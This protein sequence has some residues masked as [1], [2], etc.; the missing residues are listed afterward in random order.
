MAKLFFT[1]WVLL[2]TSCTATYPWINYSKTLNDNSVL[3]EYESVPANFHEE[4]GKVTYREVTDNYGKYQILLVGFY[5]RRTGSLFLI[6][7]NY[8]SNK[9]DLYSF[10]RSGTTYTVGIAEKNPLYANLRY[11]NQLGRMRYMHENWKIGVL[12]EDT[13]KTLIIFLKNAKGQKSI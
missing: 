1:C 4:I 9:L 10:T 6:K 11:L 13:F 5:D 12:P 7:A 3:Y 2:L 8:S